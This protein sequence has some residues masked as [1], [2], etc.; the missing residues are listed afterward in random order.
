MNLSGIQKISI[1]DP[2][3]GTTVQI[4]NIGT[5]GEFKNEPMNVE[6]AGGSKIFS[7]DNYSYSFEC[8]D[9]TGY[10]QLKTWMTSKTPVNFVAFGVDTHI[11][12][13]ENTLITVEPK[14]KLKV[15][16]L[17][18][19]SVSLE[20]KGGVLKVFSGV[21]ILQAVNGWKD[22]DLDDMAD[23]YTFSYSGGVVP[24]FS[25][26]KQILEVGNGIEIEVYKGIIFPISGIKLR[27]AVHSV[28]SPFTWSVSVTCRS[29]NNSNLLQGYANVNNN[30][31]FTT[32]N[33]T[34]KIELK[35]ISDFMTPSSDIIDF[36]PPYLG[37]TNYSGL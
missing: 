17:N 33:G 8:Y 34:Y 37:I 29:F 3:T 19:F 30:L 16:E 5:D 36:R 4:N 1:Y 11:L 10:E 12:W 7:G 14:Y 28:D 31:D 26:A 9:L 6:T 13:Q 25:V 21:N 32:P 15:G 22:D 24:S 2:V 18:G 23:G 27:L 35:I 20:K